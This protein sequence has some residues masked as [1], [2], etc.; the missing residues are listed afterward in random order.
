MPAEEVPR[1]IRESVISLNFADSGLK[2]RGLVPY[3]SRQIKARAFEVPGAG[4]FLVTEAAEGIERYY[5]PGEEIVV[6]E[7]VEDLVEKVQ[8]FLNHRDERDRIALEG[9]RRTEREHTY[10]T[11]FRQLLTTAKHMDARRSLPDNPSRKDCRIDDHKITALQREHHVGPILR[12]V[13]EAL[14]LPCVM[15]W[16][17]RRGRRAA[18]RLLYEISWSVLGRQTY[19]ARGLPGRL[20]YRES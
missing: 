8:Y 13:R 16:G 18:R 19:T 17:R 11:R 7:G 2:F 4:G 1:I 14:A 12:F 15:I 5:T 10:E 20:F 9:H 6:F 3:R